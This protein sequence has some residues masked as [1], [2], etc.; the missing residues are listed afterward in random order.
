[1]DKP[2]FVK[3]TCPVDAEAGSVNS[4]QEG[5]LF[6][7]PR[8]VNFK[9]VYHPFWRAAAASGRLASIGAKN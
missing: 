8:M 6:H 1:M 5:D 4:N 9:A 7:F 3:K 2:L